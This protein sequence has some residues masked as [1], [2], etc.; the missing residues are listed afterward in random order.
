MVLIMSKGILTP[1]VCV[2]LTYEPFEVCK[3]AEECELSVI[4]KG[5]AQCG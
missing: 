4:S 2:Q 1:L 3:H 5:K